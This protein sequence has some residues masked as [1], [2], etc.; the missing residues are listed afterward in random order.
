MYEFTRMIGRAHTKYS[1]AFM[2]DLYNSPHKGF[3]FL[4]ASING[5]LRLYLFQVSLFEMI[6][7]RT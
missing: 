7:H 2:G 5:W 3:L 6:L 4:V 1:T